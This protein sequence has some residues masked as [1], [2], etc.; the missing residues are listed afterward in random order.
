[1]YSPRLVDKLNAIAYQ[2][3]DVMLKAIKEVLNQPRYRNTGAAVDSLEIEVIEGKADRAPEIV[4]TFDD[5]VIYM[6]KRKLSWTKLPEVKNLIAWA[7][8]KTSTTQ[9]ARKLA[10]AVAWDKKKNDTWKAK[11]W[12]KRSLSGVLKE[13]NAK[14]LEAFDKAIDE[15]LQ[16][17]IN[18]GLN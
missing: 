10:W 13:M 17:A 2:Y 8:T 11:P 7:E 3:K 9:Q 5:Y 14:I 18:E 15:D 6:D 12:R 4:I 1:M 16:Q